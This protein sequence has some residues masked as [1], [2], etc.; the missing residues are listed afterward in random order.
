MADSGKQMLFAPKKTQ[1][2]SINGLNISPNISFGGTLSL[3]LAIAFGLAIAS[4]MQ[5]LRMG[6]IILVAIIVVALANKAMELNILTLAILAL[7]V[8][9]IVMWDT[10]KD[11]DIIKQIEESIGG[12]IPSLGTTEYTANPS[13]ED[14]AYAENYLYTHFAPKGKQFKIGSDITNKIIDYYDPHER[15]QHI[16]GL[17]SKNAVITADPI[18]YVYVNKTPDLETMG[19]LLMV[20]HQWVQEIQLPSG[21]TIGIYLPAEVINEYEP[22]PETAKELESQGIIHDIGQTFDTW[23]GTD[24][25]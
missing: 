19:S 18:T 1:S 16:Y 25:F 17:V 20:K 13:K 23:L 4:Y 10:V 11:M 24:W 7:C 14:I 3:V 2:P 22:N 21:K 12:A 6:L 9:A 15:K 5:D 8:F